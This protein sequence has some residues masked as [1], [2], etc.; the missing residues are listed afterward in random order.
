MKSYFLVILLTMIIMIS[1]F[2]LI[3]AEIKT[4]GTFKVNDCIDL[5]QTCGNCTWTN[6]TSVLYPNSSQA[7]GEVVMTQK[8]TEYNYSCGPS[9]T[10][11]H[12]IVNGKS[13]VDGI[14]TVWAYDYNVTPTG[15]DRLN[16]LG[17]FTILILVSIA[18]LGMAMI[19]KNGY[20]GFIAGCLFLVTGVYIMINGLGNLSNTYTQA[21]SY[22]VLGMGLIFCISAGIQIIGDTGFGI[23]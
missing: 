11:G 14:I 23:E 21:V 2:S 19:F 17:I 5:K 22:V 3:S 20:F 18:V 4:L 15:G 7:L 12:Y 10:L 16:S 1:S 8:G 9:E 6:I 13:D